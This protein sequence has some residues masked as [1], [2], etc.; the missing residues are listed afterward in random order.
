MGDDVHI[1]NQASSN[2]LLRALLPELMA[3]DDPRRASLARFLSENYLFFLNLA[4][5]AA[6]ATADWAATVEDSS[7]V[8][9]MSRNGTTYEVRLSGATEGHLAPAPPVGQSL[10]NA[11]YG[12]EDSAPDVGDSAVIELVG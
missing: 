4:M 11:G 10:Y 9:S 7:I 1:R 2:L 3:L 5:A 12:P 6:R 8:V